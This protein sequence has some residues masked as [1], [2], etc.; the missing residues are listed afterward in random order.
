MD[1]LPSQQETSDLVG[2]I[3]QGALEPLPW[4]GILR[5]LNAAFGASW[6]VLVLRPASPERP[7]LIMQAHYQ[8]AA[9]SSA[10]YT[11]Y[12][13]YFNDPFAGLPRDRIITPE[14]FLGKKEWY[15][16][17]FFLNYLQAH[18]I[19]HEI[20]ADFRTDDHADC[21]FRMCK[22][23]HAGAFTEQEKQLCEMLLPHFRRAV[24]L[25]SQMFKADV[26]KK[27]FQ[28]TFDRMRI[29][30]FILDE[31]GRALTTNN[32]ADRMLAE[33]TLLSVDS[34]GGLHC[35][36][37]ASEAQIQEA[38]RLAL[39]GPDAPQVSALTIPGG[40]EGE[41]RVLVKRIPNVNL[42]GGNQRPA[43][44]VFVHDPALRSAPRTDI[45]RALFHLTP[46]EAG[47]AQLLAEGLSLD[48]AGEQLGITH[49]TVKSRLRAIF[50]KT[51]TQRQASLMRVLLDVIT[52][53]H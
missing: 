17:D 21:R 13:V 6:A 34:K 35:R 22:P 44:A 18:D 25:Y 15:G 38:I 39:S 42:K 4:A 2:L 3:Y 43:V 14:E 27:L 7:S 9:V 41:L 10:D 45:L 12:D 26:E 20:G 11:L 29:A 40:A 23:A 5:W 24:Y 36:E 8:E 19:A 46:A 51:G 37:R 16:S 31:D 47:L 32:L 49:N 52:T 33:R 50:D 48:E 30:T 53:L 1:A 28:S